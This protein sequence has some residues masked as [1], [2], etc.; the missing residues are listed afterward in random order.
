MWTERYTSARGHFPNHGCIAGIVLRQP[1]NSLRVISLAR[2]AGSD[3]LLNHPGGFSSGSQN[4]GK[5]HIDR[6]IQGNGLLHHG[7][8]LRSSCSDCSSASSASSP[9]EHRW[10]GF[11]D[12]YIQQ[13]S[14]P[15]RNDLGFFITKQFKK[16]LRTLYRSNPIN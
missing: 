2:K 5:G 1:N 10:R 4:S 12:G 13:I 11:P 9:K 16:T 3:F 7:A 8:V 14:R 15:Y 6:A